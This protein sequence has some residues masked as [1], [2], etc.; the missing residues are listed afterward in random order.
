VYRKVDFDIHTDPKFRAMSDPPPCG[1][2]L[3][4]SLLI[5]KH[6]TLIPGVIIASPAEVCV[7]LGWVDSLADGLEIFAEFERDGL[8]Q[9]DRDAGLIWVV[10]AL[11]RNLPISPNHIRQWKGTWSRVPDCKLKAFMEASFQAL[12]EDYRKGWGKVFRKACGEPLIVES[13]QAPK[14]AL[15]KRYPNTVNSKQKAVS[16]ESIDAVQA[17]PEPV[18][19]GDPF[20]PPESPTS[21]PV[22]APATPPPPPPMEPP[23]PVVAPVAH[24]PAKPIP[25][26]ELPREASDGTSDPSPHKA[27]IDVFHKAFTKARGEPPAWGQKQGQ[28]VKTVLKRVDGD[29]TLAI[30]RMA[31][32]FAMAP[33][34][35]AENPDLATLVGHWDKFAPPP[36]TS[37]GGQR[38]S[39]TQAY[40]NEV[41]EL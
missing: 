22:A 6:T 7:A 36:R 31:R 8:V 38:A 9:V 21:E 5:G 12:L 41:K 25:Y 13:N 18:D 23:E 1:K 32:M 19:D 3:W 33:A 20:G 26:T 29:L 10:N 4:L 15:P 24:D 27:F 11:R 30:K 2:Y 28:Q 39:S 16:R 34:W 17:V 14:K 35:P 40:S 37:V